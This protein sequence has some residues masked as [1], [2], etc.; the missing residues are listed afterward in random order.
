[1]KIPRHIV[2]LTREDFAKLFRMAN[3]EAGSGIVISERG[4]RI[5]IGI[6]ENMLKVMVWTM[7]RAGIQGAA[8]GDLGSIPTDPGNL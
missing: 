6:D 5:E 8:I 2:E 7:L 1:M 4:D 3:A